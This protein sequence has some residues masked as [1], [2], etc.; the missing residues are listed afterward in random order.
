MNSGW[1]LSFLKRELE[2]LRKDKK[3]WE[4][5]LTILKNRV[6]DSNDLPIP[7]RPILH[8]WSGT[9]A[10]I[11]SLELSLHFIEKTV[12][13]AVE[14][15]RQVEN[16]DVPNLDLPDHPGLGVIDGGKT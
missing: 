3:A 12:E 9:R 13:G 7:R 10:A 16:G 14:L 5:A 8:E 4:Q 15:I 2:E 6:V 1:S 11:G